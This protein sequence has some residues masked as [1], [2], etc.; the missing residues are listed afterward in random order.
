MPTV[1]QELQ[2][3]YQGKEYL[4]EIWASFETQV[5]ERIGIYGRSYWDGEY[6]DLKVWKILKRVKFDRENQKKCALKSNIE[7]DDVKLPFEYDLTR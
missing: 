7:A 4:H 2:K 5:G 3:P 1:R 6:K